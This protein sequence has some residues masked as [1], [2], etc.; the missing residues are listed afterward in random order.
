[1]ELMGL[2]EWM[3]FEGGRG[4]T[5][6]SGAPEFLRTQDVATRQTV[7]SERRGLP[8]LSGRLVLLAIAYLMGHN[9]RATHKSLQ[10]HPLHQAHQFH[11]ADETCSDPTPSHVLKPKK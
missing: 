4:G 2:M 7:D 1:M 3:E 8:R 9:G 6:C 11:H 5:V 10:F